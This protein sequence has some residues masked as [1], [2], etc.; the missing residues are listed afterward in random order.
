MPVGNFFLAREDDGPEFGAADEEMLM[1]F[2][3]QAAAAIV[4]AQAHQQE[5]RARADLEA[6]I[7]TT[8]V[9]DAGTG[10]PVS[11]N[12]EADRLIATLRE[13]GRPAEDLTETVTCRFGDGREI[14]LNELALADEMKRAGT[15]RAA[16]PGERP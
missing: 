3:S 11:S 14:P 5:R 1:L 12:R 13:P 9:V 10:L 6:L 16:A 7:E 8:P 15:V 4:N 2:A